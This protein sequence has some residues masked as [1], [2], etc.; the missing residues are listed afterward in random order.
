MAARNEDIT[1]EKR[2][3]FKIT[4]RP[5]RTEGKEVHGLIEKTYEVWLGGPFSNREEGVVGVMATSVADDSI[6][7]FRFD[8]IVSMER[9]EGEVAA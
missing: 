9:M 2:M 1:K 3:K 8:S 7:R 5:H 4:Y 6:K